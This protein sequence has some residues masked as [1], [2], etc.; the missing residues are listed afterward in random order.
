MDI[1]DCMYSMSKICN[2]TIYP[3][4]SFIS[5]KGVGK[6]VLYQNVNQNTCPNFNLPDRLFFQ[7]HQLIGFESVYTQKY[8][9]LEII[10]TSKSFGKN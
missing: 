2:K 3:M 8:L 6:H 7:V 4:K 10:I 9:K 5:Q 1:Y